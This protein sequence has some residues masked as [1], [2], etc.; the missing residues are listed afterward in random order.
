[1]NP[2]AEKPQRDNQS[3]L[4]AKSVSRAIDRLARALTTIENLILVLSLG[5]MVLFTFI[6]VCLR[7]LYTHAGC[8]WASRMMGHLEWSEPTVR[9]LVLWVT[10]I[11]A[12]AAT[13]EGS[14]IRIDLAAVLTPKRLAPIREMLLA[15][16][17]AVVCG[18]M[19]VVSL[20]YL[21]IEM[22]M[23]KPFFWGIPSWTT[24]IILPAGFGLI[25]VRFLL[26]AAQRVFRR[27]G[28]PPF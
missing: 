1:M 19:S 4:R 10:F 3:P 7:G 22:E 24:R 23:G 28:G 25:A 2:Q 26:H 14:H 8:E 13:R 27:A 9:L 6:A 16:G 21:R 15:I 5:A 11:G 20:D 17:A 12:S 18:I